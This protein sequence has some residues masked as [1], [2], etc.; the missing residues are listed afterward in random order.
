[1]I[2]AKTAELIEMAFGLWAW[3]SSLN[4]VLDADPDHPCK[5]A[6]FRGKDMPVDFLLRAVQRQLNRWRCCLGCG[7]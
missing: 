2:C 6:I 1:M 5:G 4:H 7:L 3:L